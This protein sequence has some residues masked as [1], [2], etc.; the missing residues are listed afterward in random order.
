MSGDEFSE[1]KNYGA[2]KMMGLF[3]GGELKHVLIFAFFTCE[4]K[5]FLK[6]CSNSFC[7]SLIFDIYIGSTVDGRNP[8]PPGMYKTL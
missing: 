3:W 4:W 1:G 2:M 5:Q 7:R 6:C 8:A